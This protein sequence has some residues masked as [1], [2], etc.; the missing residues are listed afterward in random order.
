MKKI[1]VHLA[2]A[3]AACLL[4]APAVPAQSMPPGGFDHPGRIHRHGFAGHPGLAGLDLTEAQQDRVFAILHE[5]A[6]RRRELDKAERQVREALREMAASPRFDQKRAA[7]QARALGQAVADE[8]LLR[9][10]TDAQIMDVLTPE[11]RAQIERD[12]QRQERRPHA[13]Q[14]GQ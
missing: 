10:R 2:A 4:G 11:Q 13:R 5:G 12:R 1:H 7:Q 8:A 9:L 14:D 3:A 6:P